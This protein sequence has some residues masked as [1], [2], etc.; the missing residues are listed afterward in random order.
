MYL[1]RHSSG[2]SRFCALDMLATFVCLSWHNKNNNEKQ[3]CA[4]GHILL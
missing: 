1:E 4:P 3:I 2:S